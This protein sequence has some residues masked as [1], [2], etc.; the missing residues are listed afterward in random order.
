[1]ADAVTTEFD[2]G[3]DHVVLMTDADAS[4]ESKYQLPERDIDDNEP[5]GVIQPNGDINWECPCLGGLA[6]GPCAVEFREA[7]SCQQ[8]S[9]EEPKGI[10]CGDS[11][12]SLFQCMSKYSELYDTGNNDDD[13]DDI[14]D[15]DDAD[16]NTNDSQEESL[17]MK[18]DEVKDKSVA[19]ETAPPT[20]SSD[21]P[22]K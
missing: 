1:M 15:V 12:R 2:F 9:K 7:F 13:E 8:V 11:F 20:S 21:S 3:K 17:E 14:A 4:I 19:S 6:T 10:E 5:K 18:L 16:V 22:T